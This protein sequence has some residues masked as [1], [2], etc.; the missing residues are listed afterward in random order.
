HYVAWLDRF[1]PSMNSVKFWPLTQTI[2]PTKSQSRSARSHYLGLGLTRAACLL[3]IANALPAG[4]PRIPVLRKLA[5]IHGDEGLSLLGA[6]GYDGTHYASAMAMMYV[7][8]M[9]AAH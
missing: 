3:E 9:L 6:V 7:E 5:A 2:D 4:D 1:L 8:A